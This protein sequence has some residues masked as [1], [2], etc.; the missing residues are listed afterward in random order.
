MKKLCVLLSFA[1]MYTGISAQSRTTTVEY[2]KVNRDAVVHE[3][4]YPEKTVINAIQDTLE[5]LGYK[6][7]ES[8]GFLVFR[9]VQMSALG[10]DNYDLYFSTD[11]KS[12]REKD[13]SELTIMVSRGADNFVTEANDPGIIKNMRSYLDNI[14]PTVAHYDLEQQIAEQE[15][16]VRKA[17][18]RA[19]NLSD[20]ADDLQK[21]MKK[22]EE[23]IAD[24][25]KDQAKQK[26]EVE[27]QRLA[28]EALKAKRIR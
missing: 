6:G 25:I 2:Q 13:I 7:K 16:V 5:K 3:L 24:N 8:K 12:R 9:G 26:D 11:R 28:L 15:D 17:E 27:K 1:A 21:K 10:N 20:D 23:Q 18:K 4:P 19:A 22:V 14:N